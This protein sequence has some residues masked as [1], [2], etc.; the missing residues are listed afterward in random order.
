M[1]VGALL[2]A[3]AA[4]VGLIGFTVNTT[5]GWIA[6]SAGG[7]VAST[8]LNIGVVGKAVEVGIR[9]SRH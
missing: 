9:A 1:V 8:V 6:A 5:V 3:L 2:V 4:V 7:I